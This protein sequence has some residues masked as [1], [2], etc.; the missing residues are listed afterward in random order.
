M[1]NK[2]TGQ[3]VGYIKWM[4]DNYNYT[5]IKQIAEKFGVSATMIAKIRDEVNWQRI[6]P[7]EPPK[8]YLS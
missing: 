2:L 6:T 1:K 5:T 8:E 3:E 7:E 4:L